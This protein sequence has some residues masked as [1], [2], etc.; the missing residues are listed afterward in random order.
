M[1]IRFTEDLISREWLVVQPEWA[2]DAHIPMFQG[3]LEDL[4]SAINRGN[5]DLW[6]LSSS[7]L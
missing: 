2:E 7:G 4:D 6:V 5:D 3:G 1:T